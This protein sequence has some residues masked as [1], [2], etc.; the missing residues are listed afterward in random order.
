MR[1]PSAAR[2]VMGSSVVGEALV[3]TQQGAPA[4]GN[5][6]R[7]GHCPWH[8]FAPRGG[9]QGEPCSLAGLVLQTRQSARPTVEPNGP[10]SFSSHFLWAH[11]GG[12][13]LDA[14]LEMGALLSRKFRSTGCRETALRILYAPGFSMSSSL[15]LL[16]RG[17]HVVDQ[18]GVAPAGVASSTPSRLLSCRPKPHRTPFAG[19]VGRRLAPWRLPTSFHSGNNAGTP[20][21]VA[22][23]VAC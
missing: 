20:A 23:S 9:R 12:A 3:A 14:R 2:R 6:A 4:F 17:P 16:A 22:R 13:P 1:W 15:F 5:P 21:R 10:A 7:S 18:V 11:V 19:G 8:R